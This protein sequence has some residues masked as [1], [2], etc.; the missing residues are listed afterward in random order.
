MTTGC[1]PFTVDGMRISHWQTEAQRLQ[2]MQMLLS[3]RIG[4][5][6]QGTGEQSVIG[7]SIFTIAGVM[8]LGE[9]MI[10]E[11]VTGLSIKSDS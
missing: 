4:R 7:T 3:K 11:V 2:P 6:L 9:E 10:F 1:S 5:A 8:G